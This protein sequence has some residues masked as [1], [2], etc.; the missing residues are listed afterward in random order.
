V[1]RLS[2]RAVIVFALSVAAG[3]ALLS[4]GFG[5][6][7]W[8]GQ[9]RIV[10][11]GESRDTVAESLQDGQWRITCLQDARPCDVRAKAVCGGG[12]R[13]I[14][15]DVS[16]ETRRAWKAHRGLPPS[17]GGPLLARKI[18]CRE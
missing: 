9:K 5:P 4:T 7:S 8:E 11:N 12:Y 13:V 16:E 15:E 14:S 1:R 10:I 17:E 3:V 2:N 6:A 18:E